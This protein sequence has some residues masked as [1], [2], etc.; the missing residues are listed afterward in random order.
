M[1]YKKIY[2]IA[3]LVGIICGAISN[4]PPL[5]G[6]WGN[7]ILWGFAGMALGFFVRERNKI[8]WSGLL[9]GFFMSI[10]FLAS[11]FGGTSDKILGFALFSFALSI[12]G[13]FGGYIAVRLGNFLRS[14]T[15][16]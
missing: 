13:A 4:V 1:G 11:G 10:A 2:C 14:R 8:A 6:M 7:L 12:I 16:K 3:A 15:M 9:Y 5:R